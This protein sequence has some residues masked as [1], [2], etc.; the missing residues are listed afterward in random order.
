[1]MRIVYR[2]LAAVENDQDLYQAQ[3]DIFLDPNDP[4]VIKQAKEDGIP[5]SWMEAAR[6]SPIR[7][8]IVDWKVAF[9]LHPEFRTMPMVWYVPPLSPVQSQIDQGNLSTMAD[10]VIPSIETLRLPMKYLANMF[11]AGDEK[12]IVAALKAY[13]CH[14]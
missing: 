2:E 4:E 3:L 13:D 7:K 14:A 12:P 9:P 1:M 6:N 5:E 8:L 10:G 11:T